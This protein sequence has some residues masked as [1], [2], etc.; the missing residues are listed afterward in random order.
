MIKQIG[1]YDYQTVCFIG[2]SVDLREARAFSRHSLA[3]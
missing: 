3:L 1:K 2:P